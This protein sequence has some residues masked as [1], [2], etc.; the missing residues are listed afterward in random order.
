MQTPMYYASPSFTPDGWRYAIYCYGNPIVWYGGLAGLVYVAMRWVRNH[1]YALQE[2]G[3]VWHVQAKTWDVAPA[4]VLIGFA[5]QI[6]PWVLVPRGTYIYHYFA[7][8]PFLILGAVM[9]LDRL[10][11]KAPRIG[12]ITTISYLAIAL[13]MFVFLFPYASGVLAPTWWMD[14]IRNYPWTD[15]WLGTLMQAIPLVPNVW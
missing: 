13:V 6:L 11:Q 3:R 1:R 14:L 9:A 12:L 15:G 8:V 7:S 5:A 10:G 2:G 4:F